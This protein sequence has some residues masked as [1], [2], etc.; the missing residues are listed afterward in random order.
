[1]F[2]F[3]IYKLHKTLVKERTMNDLM[4]ELYSALVSVNNTFS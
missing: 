3:V 4:G 1:M 2:I